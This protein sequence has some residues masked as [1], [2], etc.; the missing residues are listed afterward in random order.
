MRV[1]E[2]KLLIVEPEK[3]FSSFLMRLLGAQPNYMF[4]FET[5]ESLSEALQAMEKEPADLVLLSL[6]LPDSDGLDT[7]RRFE[8][9]HPLVP[10]VVLAPLEDKGLALAAIRSGAQDFL[11]KDHTD[12]ALLTRAV[13]FGLERGKLLRETKT[14]SLTDELTG[15]YNR[16]GFLALAVQQLKLHQRHKRG[17]VLFFVDVDDLKYINDE[18]GHTEGDQAIR[19]VA[20]VFKSCFRDSDIL[21]R[22]GGDEF[23]ALALETGE[24]GARII[25][26]RLGKGV[27]QMNLESGRPY[28]VALSTGY[29]V[30]SEGQTADAE[31]LL[32]RADKMMYRI[33]KDKK[34]G[35]PH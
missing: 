31:E 17:L 8:S 13:E 3:D 12:A 16:R 1:N 2:V 23:V 25:L 32:M 26:D 15:L 33:K 9:Q 21:A 20:R 14:L 24:D 35:L 30:Q 22:F 6:E 28:P 19:Q 18:Y 27:R 10:V 11:V 4:R 34:K 29:A 7:F 5:C